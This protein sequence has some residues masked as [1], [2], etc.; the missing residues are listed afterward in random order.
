MAKV[1]EK[2]SCWML[3]LLKSGGDS[4]GGYG[5]IMT[6]HWNGTH[7]DFDYKPQ[8]LIS[9]DLF[10]QLSFFC[11]TELGVRQNSSPTLL[12]TFVL[13]FMPQN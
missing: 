8:S 11:T 3:S 9:C 10:E 4:V 6:D 12:N 13:R 5:D 2:G 1:D 7:H